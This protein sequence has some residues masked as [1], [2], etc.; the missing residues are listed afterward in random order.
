MTAKKTLPDQPKGRII[1]LT[2]FLPHA[3][4]FEGQVQKESKHGDE[5][6]LSTSPP[7]TKWKIAPRRGHSAMYAGLRS[8]EETE[9][10]IHVGCVGDIKD[11]NGD[12]L[13]SNFLSPNHQQTLKKFLWESEK[14]LPVFLDEKEAAG[15][16]EGYCKT[17]LWPLLHYIL[18][19]SDWAN[20]VKVNQ[21]FAD[22]VK[23]IYK[24]GDI[25][26]IHDYHLILVPRMIRQAI[27]DAIIG[28][29]LHSPF[30]SS[31]IFQILEGMLGPTKLVSRLAVQEPFG[32]CT[33]TRRLLLAETRWTGLPGSSWKD[34]PSGETRCW[35]S[36]VSEFTP[37]HH[38]NSH[39]D[40]E[41][42][43]ALLRRRWHEYHLARIFA[44]SINEALTMSS[45]DKQ[46]KHLLLYNHVSSH[47]A[48]KYQ[49]SKKRLLLFDYDGTLN[50]YSVLDGLRK[51]TSDPHNI[52]WVI[53]G[54]DQAALDEWLG[55]V[56]NLGLSAEH[57]C[58]IKYPDPENKSKWINLT[59]DL[60]LSWKNDVLAIFT[61]YT[62]RTQGSFIEHKL[63]SLTWHYRMPTRS[64][65]PSKLKN[66][67][68]TLKTR[69]YRN[70]QTWSDHD[71]DFVFCAG[72][73]KTDED[74]FRA[75][76]KAELP[77]SASFPVTIGSANKKTQALWH[78]DSPED[79]IKVITTLGASNLGSD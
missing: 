79:I 52:V 54:R 55:G 63:C 48:N 15:H 19:D 33:R 1:T 39:I 56:P 7:E 4:C 77:E 38:F 6:V 24:P 58:F 34:I 44:D 29:F 18:W 65:A 59:E 67:K 28:F 13:D 42:F 72:D 71:C 66:A 10:C 64:M 9:E 17:D 37:V 12:I 23:E 62:E 16:Y 53:S 43:Y 31:E 14:L 40:R 26:W 2:H 3:C 27:P 5:K 21:K 69:S 36:K 30:P 25:I 74:M 35:E 68:T 47:T 60:D 70:C 32:R 46:N 50:C 49:S 76:R 75:L 61:Y 73:D 57:G 41:E 11:V 51:L 8:L 20:Y 78:V 22:T 45:E